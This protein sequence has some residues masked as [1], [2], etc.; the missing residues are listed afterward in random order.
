MANVSFYY[1]TKA[2]YNSLQTKS[3]D[4]LY[5]ITDTLQLYKGEDEY[6]KSMQFVSQLPANGE[7]R[8]GILYILQSDFSAY[9]FTGQAYQKLFLGY[10]TAIPNVSPTDDNVPTTKAV[11]DYVNAK[12][13]AITGSADGWV[14][15][16]TYNNGTLTVVKSSGGTETTLSHVAHDVSYDVATQTLTVP[17]FGDESLSINFAQISSVSGG[18]YNSETGNIELV[19]GNGNIV[20]IPIGSLIDVYT[21]IATQTTETSV[22]NDNKISVRV[23]LSA[24][25]NNALTLEQDGLYVPLPDAYTKAQIDGLFQTVNAVINDHVNN[26]TAHVTDVERATWNAKISSDQLIAAKSEAIATAAADA[27][28]KADQALIDAKTYA[29]GLNSNMINRMTVVERSIIWNTIPSD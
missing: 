3:A 22:S 21:G 18:Q 28:E 12:I 15:D 27:T 1:G 5:F 9:R 2:N 19:L 11:A 24:S 26:S 17:M 14:S 16:V 7:A 6:T 8:Q 13:A 20:E 25:A 4:T 23:K 10:A 29:D